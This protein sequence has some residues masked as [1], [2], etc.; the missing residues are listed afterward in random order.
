MSRWFKSA[1]LIALALIL[2]GLGNHFYYKYT[3]GFRI[4]YITS[5]LTYHPTWE[6]NPPSQQEEVLLKTIFKQSF[7]YLGKGGKAYAFESED[8]LYVLKFLK[9]KYLRPLFFNRL[10]SYIPFFEDKDMNEIQRRHRKFYGVFQGYMWAYDLNK[11]NSGLIF[12][13]FN[14]TFNRFGDV[15]LY[16]KMGRKH[17]IDLDQV[18]FIVQEKAQLLNEVLKEKLDRGDLAGVQL[19]LSK[20]IDLFVDQ[21]QKGLYDRDLGVLHNTGFVDDRPV[22]I[23]MGKMTYDESMKEK[24]HYKSHLQ[25]VSNEMEHWIKKHYPQF[26]SPFM[27]ILEDKLNKI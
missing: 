20:I 21:Y 17:R 13:H 6:I 27:K 3:D 1:S 14:P 11:T 25:E 16:D 22:H 4:E 26:H 18:V 10:I 5:K 19:T 23:D 8:G 2:F 9:F 24:S 15:V 12:L 7:N